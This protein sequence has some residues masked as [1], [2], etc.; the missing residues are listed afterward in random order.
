MGNILDDHTDIDPFVDAPP[1]E[2]TIK[3]QQQQQGWK[4]TPVTTSVEG[5]ENAAG[6]PSMFDKLFDCTPCMNMGTP[7]FPAAMNPSPSAVFKS[8]SCAECGGKCTK[9]Q[10]Y[11]K[12]EVFKTILVVVDPDT[13]VEK[14]MQE[15]TKMY[16]HKWC[17]QV[18][19][20]R[21]AHKHR[22]DGDDYAS[23]MRNPL[24]YF[25]A[26]ELEAQLKREAE[27][28]RQVQ[29]EAAVRLT[30]AA[31]LEQAAKMDAEKQ[32]NKPFNKKLLKNVKKSFSIKKKE[33]AKSDKEDRSST[34]SSAT[35]NT[36]TKGSSSEKKS[37]S[38]K[39]KKKAK[40]EKGRSITNNSSAT[41]PKMS[42]KAKG[43][44]T[45]KPLSA[46]KAAL[47]NVRRS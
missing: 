10:G 34:K 11:K 41:S 1:L 22:D 44:T 8:R 29:A 39:K 14:E 45:T 9:L 3:Q 21:D 32:K 28:R 23:V 33:K 19:E 18:K 42:T 43:S 2:S 4:P 46:R 40:A 17:H 12:E 13:G 7:S 26:L 37:F 31:E 30:L 47:A 15:A 6:N 27:L 25:R 35:P 16:Y 20:Y 5:E 38:I 36:T 24:D